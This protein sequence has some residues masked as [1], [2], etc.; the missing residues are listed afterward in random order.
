MASG[1]VE[2]DAPARYWKVESPLT[3]SQGD[4]K[5]VVFPDEKFRISCI[6]S[7]G[8][9]PLDSQFFSGTVTPETFGGDIAQARTFVLYRELEQL[10]AMGLV[11][12]GSLDNAIIIHDGAIISKEGLRQPDELVRHKVLD[13]I[14]DLYLVGRRV[15]AHV[16]AYKPGHPANVAM[17]LKMIQSA[18]NGGGQCRSTENQ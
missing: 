15:K 18:N 1:V 3:V 16:L 5:L 9:T 7:Y 6:I 17:A 2:Q 12:G 14:G 10:L 8:A 13:V 11:K 4:T